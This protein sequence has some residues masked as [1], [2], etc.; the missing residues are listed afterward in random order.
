MS[1][2]SSTNGGTAECLKVSDVMRLED[3][4]GP[5]PL[6]LAVGLTEQPEAAR[7]Y[8][9]THGCVGHECLAG[10]PD[11]IAQESRDSG[12]GEPPL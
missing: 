6:H 12:F 5:D 8:N 9:S 11:G 3:M 2:I 10:L 1:R 4:R 7:G